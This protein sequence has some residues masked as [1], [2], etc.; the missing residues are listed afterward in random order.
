MKTNGKFMVLCWFLL[1]QTSSARNTRSREG[2]LQRT[3]WTLSLTEKRPKKHS[4][5]LSTHVH[6]IFWTFFFALDIFLVTWNF[7]DGMEEWANAMPRS[8]CSTWQ[9]LTIVPRS[10][11]SEITSPFHELIRPDNST[12]HNSS[13]S[14]WLRENIGL[15]S[16]CKYTLQ[17]KL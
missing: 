5:Y 1:L 14:G 8:P 17:D 4:T 3:H 2:E 13:F 16:P 15:P 10:A 7:D 9:S 12:I 6:A 11:T